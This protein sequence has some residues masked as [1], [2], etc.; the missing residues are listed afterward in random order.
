MPGMSASTETGA[1]RDCAMKA[2]V[3]PNA[4]QHSSGD[5]DNGT[6]EIA[7]KMYGRSTCDAN[8]CVRGSTRSGIVRDSRRV[9]RLDVRDDAQSRAKPRFT[10]FRAREIGV[11]LRNRPRDDDEPLGQSQVSITFTDFY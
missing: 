1:P 4:G 10:A 9:A 6:A 7:L 2:F 3:R 8:V 11:R 5:L